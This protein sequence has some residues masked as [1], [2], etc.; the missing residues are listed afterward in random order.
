M[1]FI[2]KNSATYIKSPGKIIT[3]I[4]FKLLLIF[5]I[6]DIIDISMF[7]TTIT[8]VERDYRREKNN[9]SFTTNASVLK[10]SII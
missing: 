3:L 1:S 2:E 6:I 7:T 4:F 9:T 5:D 10:T 8:I